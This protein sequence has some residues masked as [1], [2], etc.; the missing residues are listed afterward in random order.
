M[1]E[2]LARLFCSILLVRK[3]K[4]DIYMKYNLNVE[5][6][7]L[8]A[9]VFPRI[10]PQKSETSVWTVPRARRGI[11]VIHGMPLHRD[12]PC[13]VGDSCL[14]SQ[15]MQRA[16]S[17]DAGGLRRDIAAAAHTQKSSGSPGTTTC[18]RA[19]FLVCARGLAWDTVLAD[20]DRWG[21]PGNSPSDH[22]R[23]P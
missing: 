23:E 15:P 8:R 22:I 1:R 20:S 18:F 2:N 5:G 9:S 13:G 11:K 21:A 19:W 14:A 3:S 12:H 6:S 7:Y 10:H 16:R 17:G 4:K